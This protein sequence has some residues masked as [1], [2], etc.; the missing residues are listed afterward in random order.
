MTNP[1]FRYRPTF[2]DKHKIDTTQF[3]AEGTFTEVFGM[4]IP[5]EIKKDMG[6]DILPKDLVIKRYAGDRMEA[7]LFERENLTPKEKRTFLRGRFKAIREYFAND[8]PDLVVKTSITTAKDMYGNE[9]VYE[10]QPQLRDFV[11]P[12][13]TLPWGDIFANVPIFVNATRD[14]SSFCQAWAEQARQEIVGISPEGGVGL[15]EEFKVFARLAR[16]V[17]YAGGLLNDRFLDIKGR[18]NYVVTK[19][20][21]RLLDTNMLFSVSGDRTVYAIYKA[22]LQFLDRLADVIEMSVGK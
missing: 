10:I 3:F 22:Q 9:Q 15:S 21:T 1:E 17:P 14:N 4:R 19:E 18:K 12:F 20:G 7:L 16:D 5:A 8:L 2:I 11:D 13:N 6:Q